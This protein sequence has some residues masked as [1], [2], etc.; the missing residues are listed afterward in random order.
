MLRSIDLFA[1]AGGLSLGMQSAGID[2]VAA[3]ECEK[4]CIRTLEC[5]LKDATLHRDDIR[6]VNLSQYRGATDLVMGGPPC[7]PFSSGGLRAGGNDKRD[8]IPSFIHAV[9][10]IKPKAFLMENVKGLV[11]K[12]RRS[13]FDGLLT[14]L[15]D[16]G[17]NVTW[18]LLN[19]ADY[20][21]PQKRI[22]LFVVGMLQ[23]T[24]SFPKS[25]HGTNGHLP[26][27]TVQDALSSKQIGE[28]NHSKVTY[29]KNPDLRPSPYHGQLFNGGGRPLD[30]RQPAPTILAAAGG[31]RTHFFDTENLVPSYHRH[32]INGGSPKCGTLRGARRLTISESAILQ[33]FPGDFTFSGSKSSQYTQIGNAVPPCLAKLLGQSLIEQLSGGAVTYASINKPHLYL[34][35]SLFVG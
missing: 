20:G 26:Q 33:T 28:S 35:P 13:Y 7:Q 4:D 11:V 14:A 24:F 15:S 32:L 29:A 16:L 21:V 8:M 18:Q 17:Y 19:A 30:L 10:A 3:V 12:E 31:N 27:T 1:G 5:H 6:N 2:V 23:D 25:S 9:A 22:R 34:Q